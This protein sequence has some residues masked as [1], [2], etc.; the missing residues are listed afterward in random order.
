[1]N[2]TS[3]KEAA[4]HYGVPVGEVLYIMGDKIGVITEIAKNTIVRKVYGYC[5][6]PKGI[7]K[8]KAVG[9]A[10]MVLPVWEITV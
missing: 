4:D 8:V 6:V 1:M 7:V 3:I 10:P 9:H 2:M 5:R